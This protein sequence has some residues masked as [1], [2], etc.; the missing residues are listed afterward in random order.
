MSHVKLIA[1]TRAYICH[2]NMKPIFFYSFWKVFAE[3]YI[4][5]YS[6]GNKERIQSETATITGDYALRTLSIL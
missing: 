1:E 2:E 6:T 3:K 4:K 5:K